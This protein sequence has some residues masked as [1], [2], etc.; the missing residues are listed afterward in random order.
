MKVAI[1]LGNRLNDDGTISN[2]QIERLKMVFELEQDYCPDYYILSGGVANTLANKSEAKAMYDYLEEQ[3]FNLD[4]LILEDKSISTK[5]NA[6]YCKPIIEK[7]NPDT[8]IICTSAYHLCDPIYGT[9]SH[10]YNV[11]KNKNIKFITYTI[12]YGDKND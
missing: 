7:L 2:I 1:I 6:L 12:N 9:M 5:E 8:L 4:K 3:G 11:I 10:F